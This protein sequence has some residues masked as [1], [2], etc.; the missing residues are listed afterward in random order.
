MGFAGQGPVRWRLLAQ[1]ASAMLLGG[2]ISL[3]REFAVMTAGLRTY[4]LVAGAATL[5]AALSN[6]VI[7]YLAMTILGVSFPGAGTIIHGPARHRVVGL[8]SGASIPMRPPSRLEWRR[9]C[10]CLSPAVVCS[11]GLHCAD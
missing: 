1:V 9:R 7:E 6:G 8:A 2:A 11:P 5:L 10:G 4:M 3:E